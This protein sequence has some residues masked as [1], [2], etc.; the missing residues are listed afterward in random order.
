MKKQTNSVLKRLITLFIVILVTFGAINALWFYGY[1]I[2]YNRLSN[3][4][5]VAYNDINPN[6]KRYVRDEGGYHFE[7]KMPEYLGRGG[8]ISVAKEEGAITYYD[9]TG[10]ITGSNGMF[11]SLYIWPKYF[12]KYKMGIDLYDEVERVSEQIVITDDIQ[13]VVNGDYDDEYI[14]Y[15]Q[16]LLNENYD[17][18]IRLINVADTLL[19]IR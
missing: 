7:L 17:E 19:K 6:I 13:V 15:L 18:I 2:Q 9:E 8:F 14:Q 3:V 4:L 5:E 12:G 10:T 16:D 1:K 11:V